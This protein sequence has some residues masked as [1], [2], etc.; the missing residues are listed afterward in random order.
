MKAAV[1]HCLTRHTAGAGFTSYQE[2]GN[3]SEVG[4][5]CPAGALDAGTGPPPEVQR[6]LQRTP[7]DSGLTLHSKSSISGLRHQLKHELHAELYVARS[8]S[9]VDNA[10]ARRSESSVRTAEVCM[11]EQVKGLS[12]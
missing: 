3:S 11:V 9:T 5:S 7:L 2:N 10:E 4:P 12:T 6:G 1:L 8:C